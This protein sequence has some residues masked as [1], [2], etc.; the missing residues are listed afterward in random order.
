MAKTATPLPFR[1]IVPSAVVPPTKK[2]TFPVAVE[3]VTV[4]VRVTLWP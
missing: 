3:G 4:A 2:L 1:A